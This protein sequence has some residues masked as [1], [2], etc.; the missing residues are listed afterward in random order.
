MPSGGLLFS[1]YFLRSGVEDLPEWNAQQPH[2]LAHALEQIVEVVRRAQAT[3]HANESVSE[4]LVVEPVLRLLGWSEWLRQQTL[5]PTGRTD[6]PDYLLF[7]D[8]QTRQQALALAHEHRRYRLGT[9]FLE[10]KKWEV[11]LD[12]AAGT[13][14]PSTQMLRYLSLAEVQSDQRIRFAVLTNGRH[15]RLYDQKARSRAEEFLEIDLALIASPDL[16]TQPEEA[17]R[18]LRIFLLFFSRE[19]FER[20]EHGHTLHERALRESR[21]YEER[22]T[23]RLADTVF[24]RVFRELADALWRNDPQSRDDDDYLEELREATLIYLYRLLFTLFAEDRH[25]LPTHN[26]PD[27]LTLMR[28]EIALRADDR[29][30]FSPT[31]VS[32]DNDLRQLWAQIDQGDDSLGIPPY[33]GGLFRDDQ[34]ILHRSRIPDAEFAPIL[35]G[36]SRTELVLAR[37][38]INY[39]DLSVQHLGSVYER[40]LEYELAV[41]DGH[42]IQ[43]PNRFA[44]KTSGSYYTPEEL[45][46]LII[47]RTIGPLVEERKAAFREVPEGAD[48]ETVE[49]TDPASRILDLTV[50]DPAMGSGHF[51][52]SL[53]DWLADRVLEAMAEAEAERPGYNSP[54]SDRLDT[55]ASHIQEEADRRGWSLPIGGLEPRHLVRRIILKRVIH[56]VD[57]N[58]MAVELAK[59]SLWLHTFTVGAPL[60]FLDHHLR[61][62]DSLFGEWVRDAQD[63]LVRRR[64]MMTGALITGARQ[65]VRAMVEIEQMSDADIH[66]VHTSAERFEAVEHATGPLNAMLSFVQAWRWLASGDPADSIAFNSLVDGSEGDPDQIALGL[67]EPRS[68]NARSL[69]ERLRTIAAQERF[70][71]WQVAFPNRWDDWTSAEPVGGFDAVIGNPPWAKVELD[72]VNWFTGRDDIIAQAR[73]DAIRNDMIAEL[74]TQNPRLYDDYLAARESFSRAVGA[75]QTSG[76]YPLFSRGRP[77][78]YQL[79]YEQALRL[80]NPGGI[81]GLLVPSGIIADKAA[82]AFV[83]SIAPAGRLLVFTDF[84]NRLRNQSIFFQEVHP[85]A[86]FAV[87]VVGGAHRAEPIFKAS[88]FSQTTNPAELDEISLEIEPAMLETLNPNTGTAMIFRDGRDAG[89]TMAAYERVPIVRRGDQRPVWPVRFSQMLNQATDSHLF[90]SAESLQQRGYYPVALNRWQRRARVLLPVYEGK[91]VQAYDHRAADVAINP[92]NRRRQGQ[93]QDLNL[94]EH[95]DPSRYPTPRHFISRAKVPRRARL[96]WMIGYKDITATTNR[97]T[98]I[99]A[100]IPECGAVHTLPVLLP[101]ENE[102]PAYVRAAPLVLANLNSFAF[103]YFARQKVQGTHIS[104]YIVEQL[105]VIRDYDR[106]FGEKSAAQI[107]QDDVLALTYTSH[108]MEPFARDLGYEG[109]PFLW[110][111]DDRR[112]RQARLDALYFHLYGLDIQ[113][114]E[115]ILSTFP[116]VERQDR[117]A[118]RR[119]L[120]RDLILAWMNALAADEPD[121]EIV[122]PPP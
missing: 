80:I 57:K 81:V 104:W 19:A 13:T 32:Y 56:G 50:C 16:I 37:K 20:D 55:I 116:I 27:G 119:Y 95:E 88:F 10:A 64:A 49:R 25:L 8:D 45:V 92:E 3:A 76:Y 17:E 24:D 84:G 111:E 31:R 99:A 115:Y 62:G 98:M 15:W 6:V 38:H 113:E 100:I 65:S 93:G 36:L 82:S 5:S 85:S 86:H 42:L 103:D 39:R 4:Q 107:V 9:T 114:A 18:A 91:M 75:A 52:V 29:I 35:D 66:E 106:Q 90:E 101:I 120:T 46:L 60:S 26:H 74:R 22:V 118:H 122:L 48:R 58:P 71:H 44:R 33:N 77:D 14:A 51:L 63:F 121:A 96:P 30:A 54:L 23:E 67:A 70:L 89:I 73:T 59:L 110:D 41:E 87:T 61:T 53:V 21:R 79:F 1:D 117:A 78:L 108:D 97:R 11:P 68:A 69:T 47:E 102:R 12:R 40:L 34:P 28:D 94:G 72:V 112:N 105:P 2:D 109:S 43:R 7:R 83:R